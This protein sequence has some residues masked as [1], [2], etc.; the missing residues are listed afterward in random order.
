MLNHHLEYL[1]RS[2]YITS[3]AIIADSK[4]VKFAEMALEW[5]D[6]KHGWHTKGCVALTDEYSN[7]LCY[8]FYYIDRY[9]EYI[10]IH[11]IFTPFI[12][13]RNGYAQILLALI[14][15][16]A[17]TQ[18]VSRFKLT[19]I[20]KSLDFYLYL[21]FIYWGVNSAGDYYCDLPIPF[22]GLSGIDYMVKTTS[23]S[24][25]IGK[26]FDK[27]YNKVE[28]NNTNLSSLKTA[29]YNSDLLKMGN[30]YLLETIIEMKNH[31]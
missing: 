24:S 6:K 12:K 20:S 27:I 10:T 31:R 5:W 30:H 22:D 16:L 14:F 11:N 3:V 28:N 1:S 26:H 9:H 18:N 21:G 17:L 29:I 7:H 4:T 19:S 25:L 23:T 15:D 13:R 2:E 8:V